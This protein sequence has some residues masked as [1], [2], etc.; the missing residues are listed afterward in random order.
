ML[1]V[2]THLSTSSL[3]IFISFPSLSFSF[4]THFL[5]GEILIEHIILLFF[6]PERSEIVV[7]IFTQGLY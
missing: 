7:F 1:E 4:L 3:Y 2:D 5:L 6:R